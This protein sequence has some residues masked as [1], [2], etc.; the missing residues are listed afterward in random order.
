M[1]QQSKS[2]ILHFE[3]LADLYRQVAE[4]S[5]HRLFYGRG[6]IIRTED[7][8]N[9]KMT[10]YHFPIETEKKMIDALMAGK[11]KDAKLWFKEISGPSLYIPSPKY[12]CSCC[13]KA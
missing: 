6:C 13:F 2:Y 1:L 9:L 12:H 3:Y 7:I 5:L 8:S 11:I 10:R 4:A